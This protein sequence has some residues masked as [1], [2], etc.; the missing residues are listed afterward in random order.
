MELKIGQQYRLKLPDR[1]GW[2]EQSPEWQLAQVTL[3]EIFVNPCIDPRGPHSVCDCED[4]YVGDYTAWVTA[5][6]LKTGLPN[7][8]FRAKPSWLQEL[9]SKLPCDCPLKW[10][11]SQG[12]QNRNHE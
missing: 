7:N 9:S 12:C 3:V 5:P 2:T 8:V 11:I 6:G 4:C 1:S 10:V